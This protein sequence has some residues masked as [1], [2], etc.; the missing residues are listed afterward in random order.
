MFRLFE[1]L[2]GA[3]PVGARPRRYLNRALLFA[4][5][6]VLLWLSLQLLPARTPPDT[7]AVYSDASGTVASR[8]DA[9]PAPRRSPR[10]VTPGS[11]FAFLILAGGGGFAY[12]LRRHRSRETPAT[13]FIEPLAEY[14]LAPS[15]QLRLVRCAGEVLLLGVTAGQITLLK[16]YPAGAFEVTETDNAP[17]TAGVVPPVP[18]SDFAHS[19]F[20]DVLRHYAHRYT[21]AQ[22]SARHA[23]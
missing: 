12:Y 6:L 11:F 5:G 21:H 18:A 22:P 9:G 10:L 2:S 20:A 19:H 3:A 16:T 23:R 8:T 14:A 1:R 15:Q 4:G 17:A 7:H 13:A